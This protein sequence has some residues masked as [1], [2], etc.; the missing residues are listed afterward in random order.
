MNK[1][2]CKVLSMF[3]IWVNTTLFK[4]T[5]DPHEEV[6]KQLER[7]VISPPNIKALILTHLHIDH[8]LGIKHFEKTD[9]LVNKLEWD[10]PSGDVARLYLQWFKADPFSV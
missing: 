10:K 1:Q 8:I 2:Y 3:S 9:I 7:L 6:D 5:V 4:F